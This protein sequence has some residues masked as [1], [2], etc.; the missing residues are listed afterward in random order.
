[1]YY[2]CTG[3]AMLHP[4]LMPGSSLAGPNAPQPASHNATTPNESLFLHT[5]TD[6][7]FSS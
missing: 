2:N 4:I 5:L 3:K 6:D 7:G 1:M